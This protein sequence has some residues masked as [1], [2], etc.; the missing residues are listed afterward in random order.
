MSLRVIFQ[1][2]SC[3]ASA[4]AAEIVDVSDLS[5]RLEGFDRR[6]ESIDSAACDDDFVDALTVCHCEYLALDRTVL[7]ADEL[8]SAVE[9][10]RL[11]ALRTRAYGDYT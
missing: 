8:V 3:V 6:L 11:Y 1:K 10:G 4:A 7:V 9:L 2:L 5:T